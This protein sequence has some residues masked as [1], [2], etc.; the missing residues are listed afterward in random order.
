MVKQMRLTHADGLDYD[1][2]V[3]MFSISR[4]GSC[5]GLLKPGGRANGVGLSRETRE[6]ECL[7]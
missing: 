1:D 3:P 6:V 5:A 4:M 2:F 7:S